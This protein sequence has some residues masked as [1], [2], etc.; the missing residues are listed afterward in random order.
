VLFACEAE[1]PKIGHARLVLR[2]AGAEAQMTVE[3]DAALP[4]DDKW[5]LIEER[6]AR[7]GGNFAWEHTSSG[8]TLID[9]ALPAAM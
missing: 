4:R 1:H 3:L 5:L 2:R 6:V 7:M 9:V 8:A